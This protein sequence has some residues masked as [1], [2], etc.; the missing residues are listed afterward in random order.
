MLLSVEELRQCSHRTTVSADHGGCIKGWIKDLF[1]FPICFT[2]QKTFF[3]NWLEKLFSLPWTNH[4]KLNAF[5]NSLLDTA[6][7]KITYKAEQTIILWVDMAFTWW[8]T[9]KVVIWESSLHC[10]GTNATSPPF[11]KL[12]LFDIIYSQSLSAEYD[13]QLSMPAVISQ[14]PVIHAYLHSLVIIIYSCRTSSM[15][16]RPH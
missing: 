3:L 2:F 12:H 13:S 5:S 1:S 10:F 7:R 15:T 8:A 6:E 16:C 11:K 9:C 4:Y 14:L